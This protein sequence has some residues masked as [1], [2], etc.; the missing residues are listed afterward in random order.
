[1]TYDIIATLGPAS[2]NESIWQAMIAA[3]A[4]Q[5]RLNSSHMRVADV[6]G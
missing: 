6:I 2:S 4:T 5:F 1:M 3:G